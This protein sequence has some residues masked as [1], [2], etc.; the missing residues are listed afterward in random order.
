MYAE[1]TNPRA[2]E[3]GGAG[4]LVDGQEEQE[5]DDRKAAV[6]SCGYAKTCRRIKRFAF[7]EA[8]ASREW[9]KRRSLG[10]CA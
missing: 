5:S 4:G 2:G 6:S 3:G 1:T 9:R 7:Q 10:R 8:Q